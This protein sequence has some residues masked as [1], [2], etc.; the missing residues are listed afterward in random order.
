MTPQE[1]LLD[2]LDELKSW[3]DSDVKR[4]SSILHWAL[5][6]SSLASQVAEEAAQEIL[7]EMQLEEIHEKRKDYEDGK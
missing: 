7:E 6:V 5:K 1:R 3:Q 2:A 4:R